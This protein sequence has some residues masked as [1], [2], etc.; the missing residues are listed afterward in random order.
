[1]LSSRILNFSDIEKRRRELNLLLPKDLSPKKIASVQKKIAKL[2]DTKESIS[3]VRAVI[4][5]INEMGIV[6]DVVYEIT[7]SN[8][9]RFLE[10]NNDLILDILGIFEKEHVV[11]ASVPYKINSNKM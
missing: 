3:F 6:M 5:T 10:M 11:L 2:F 8:F 7:E 9:D 4:S 1:V